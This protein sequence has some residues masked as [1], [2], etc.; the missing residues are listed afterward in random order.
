MLALVVAGLIVIAA[1][2]PKTFVLTSRLDVWDVAIADL[3]GDSN[4]DIL[5]FSADSRSYPL[6]K[7]LMAF[8][9][10]DVGGYPSEPSAELRLDASV[11]TAFIAETDGHP[12]QEVIVMQPSGAF[13]YALGATGFEVL[14]EA[15][16]SS[17]YPSGASEPIFL[18]DS[19]VDLDGDGIDE[20][21]IPV[22]GGYEI[23]NQSG[24]IAA[25][26]AHV[27]S[28]IRTLGAL[29]IQ[30]RLPTIHTF[31]Q[32]GAS[33]KGLAF[34]SDR[35]ADFSY[36][37]GWS[38]HYR[39]R[40]PS[41]LDERWESYARMNDING[42]GFPDL[43]VTQTRGTISLEVQTQV[44]IAEGPFRYPESPTVQFRSKG[45]FTTP[46]LLDVNQD[47]KS[48]IV[49]MSV[50]LGLRNII[51]YFFRKK[52]SI[53]IDAHLYTARGFDQKYSFRTH[54]IVDAPEGRERVA[55][56]MGDFTGDGQIDAAIGIGAEK[57]AVYKGDAK[58]FLS[59]SP[60][61][62]FAVPSFGVARS[63][64]LDG[65]GTEDI[66]LFHPSGDHQKRIEV[67]LF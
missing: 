6:E 22:S 39:Y 61:K 20:W 29:V 56:T 34:L 58:T 64:D 66:V 32:P 46:A 1:D 24:L 25:V 54:I 44:Y 10:D 21:L 62:I 13:V 31:E 52:M 42:D 53:Q 33:T 48:D 36:G 37:P 5:V 49:F 30:H 15:R 19:A 38:K 9:A 43:L 28:E 4:L 45:S 11:G 41:D 17:L 60:W 12:P 63:E 7:S 14:A 47:G 23:R 18:L 65:N 40:I 2:A 26:P 8:L 35:F 50:S 27:E 16:F 57:F 55:Y 3:N 59:G 51:N 67:I